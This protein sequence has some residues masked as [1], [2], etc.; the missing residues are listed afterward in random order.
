MASVAN[1]IPEQTVA[2]GASAGR[3]AVVGWGSTYGSIFQA[4]T[5]VNEPG[6]SQIHIRYLSP[7]PKNLGELLSGF[8]A[9]LVPE[10]N[11]GQLCT[12]LRDKLGLNPIS[13]PKVNG[14]PF[15]VAEIVDAIRAQLPDSVVQ[16]TQT[17]SR[18]D[19]R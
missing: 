2:V 12:V 5:S 18:G 9:I 4:V 16:A 7:F 13:L 6:V 14:Q 11:M 1:F 10:M 19:R 3:L 15:L 17:A 8:E